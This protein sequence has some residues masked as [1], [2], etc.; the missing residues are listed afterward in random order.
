MSSDIATRIITTLFLCYSLLCIDRP[1]QAR[2]QAC[3]SMV[4]KLSHRNHVVQNLMCVQ[5][6]IELTV[7]SQ[8]PRLS[9]TKISGDLSLVAKIKQQ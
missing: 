8:R 6:K 9:S 2:S 4:A 1:K 5:D 7:T 3:V